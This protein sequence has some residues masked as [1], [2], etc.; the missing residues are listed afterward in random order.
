MPEVSPLPTVDSTRLL[1]R[2]AVAVACG[3][4]PLPSWRGGPFLAESQTV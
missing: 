3:E 4:A 2:A 1:A